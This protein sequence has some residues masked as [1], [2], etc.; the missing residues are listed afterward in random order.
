MGIKLTHSA[1]GRVFIYR[2]GKC[3]EPGCNWEPQGL[4]STS[5][6]F[7]EHI[8]HA[9]TTDEMRTADEAAQQ[10][11]KKP[12]QSVTVIGGLARNSDP[13]PSHL[14]AANVKATKRERE[15]ESALVQLGG[16]GTTED[17]IDSLNQM[18]EGREEIPSNVSGRMRPMQRK[19]IVR[20]SGQ[21]K[22]SRQREENTVYEL[23][24]AHLRAET[25]R[26]FREQEEKEMTYC[27]N[28]KHKHR[29]KKAPL[30]KLA[31]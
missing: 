29:C 23:V 2:D 20:D 26:E 9:H 28:C 31:S 15:V 17:I 5:A 1:T 4:G 12:P 27:P 25:G 7:H 8:E 16:R 6:E 24:P 18:F 19:G 3:E 30:A 13:N 10:L 21:V 14:A 22:R 11:P